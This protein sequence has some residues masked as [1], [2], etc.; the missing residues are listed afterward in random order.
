M[1]AQHLVFFVAGLLAGWVTFYTLWF[2]ADRIY[3]A[4]AREPIT[5]AEGREYGRRVWSVRRERLPRATRHEPEFLP[6]RSRP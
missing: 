5:P 3:A 6:V 1:N 2:N 4:L